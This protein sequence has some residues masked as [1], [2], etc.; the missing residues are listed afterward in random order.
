MNNS[1][2]IIKVSSLLVTNFN[3]F[4]S[5]WSDFAPARWGK[6]SS[7][8]GE[9]TN[10]HWNIEVCQSPVWPG[11]LFCSPWSCPTP[12]GWGLVPS[13][14]GKPAPP[15]K[16]GVIRLFGRKLE[17]KCKLLCERN[18]KCSDTEDHLSSSDPLILPLLQWRVTC[19]DWRRNVIIFSNY[20][21]SSLNFSQWTR[22]EEA[23]ALER[24][25]RPPSVRVTCLHVGLTVR[26]VL[27]KQLNK[28]CLYILVLLITGKMFVKTVLL[29]WDEIVLM[30]SSAQ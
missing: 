12:R 2:E 7:Q 3:I 19:S 9:T 13:H 17:L 27:Y 28:H 30:H 16:C 29:F 21:K 15:E 14:W 23:K 10:S 18:E 20:L 6:N 25:E 4:V 24:E 11:G 8:V 26:T 22:R 1:E 5:T